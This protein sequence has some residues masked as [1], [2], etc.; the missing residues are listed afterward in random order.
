M[1][2]LLFW[3]WLIASLSGCFTC[4]SNFCISCKLLVRHRNSISFMFNCWWGLRELRKETR[5]THYLVMAPHSRT[6]AW[7]IPWTEEPGGLQSMG[8][9]RVRHDWATSLWLFT[10]MHWRRKWQPTPVFLPR[11]SQGL[12]SLVGCRLWG[13]T[14][15]ETTSDL[16]AAAAAAAAIRLQPPLMVQLEETQDEKTQDPGPR[17]PR[18]DFS[19]PK[20]L[21]LPIPRKVLNSLTGDICFSFINSYLL[22]WLCVVIAKIPI[23]PGIYAG[24]TISFSKQF[25][26]RGSTLKLSAE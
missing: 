25:Y 20:L 15:S 9:L 3:L 12:G 10:F 7:R 16:A 22:F 21:H 17:E 19:E 24:F 18:N 23:Y 4:F 2:H 6:L 26:P 1:Q 11:E 8:S 13:R 5:N 14:G